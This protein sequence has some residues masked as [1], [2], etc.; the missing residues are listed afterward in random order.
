MITALQ[1]IT[2]DST[3][4]SDAI[5]IVY[6]IILLITIGITAVF[7]YFKVKPFRKKSL[8]WSFDNNKQ[9]FTFVMNFLRVLIIM[10]DGRS[11]SFLIVS[12][13]VELI[14]RKLSHRFFTKENQKIQA[15]GSNMNMS[16]HVALLVYDFTSS[17]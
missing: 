4:L 2:Q 17:A 5:N 1:A 11:V 16:A 7:T 15:F 13:L 6:S 3:K 10:I 14:L 12:F 8:F 9:F